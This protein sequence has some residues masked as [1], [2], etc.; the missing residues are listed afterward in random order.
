[1][2]QQ[3]YTQPFKQK[4]PRGKLPNMEDA[5]CCWHMIPKYKYDHAKLVVGIFIRKIILKKLSEKL[6][7]ITNDKRWI[8]SN[9][10]ADNYSMM[11]VNI[12]ICTWVALL[13]VLEGQSEHYVLEFNLQLND[14][15]VLVITG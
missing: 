12:F 6:V 11:D 10:K 8:L 1:M 4:H 9:D 5:C 2:T 15:R 13:I 7:E 14:K 3:A